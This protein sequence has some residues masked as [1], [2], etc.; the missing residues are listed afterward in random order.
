LISKIYVVES[1]TGDVVQKNNKSVLKGLLNCT[2]HDSSNEKNTESGVLKVQF[3]DVSYHHKKC[4]FCWEVSYFA[5]NELNTPI[6][7]IRSSSFKVFAR[8]PS[9]V[10][11]LTK[12]KRKKD[13]T[14]FD[15]FC[16]R[17]DELVKYTKKLKTD[18]QKSALELV[19]KKLLEFQNNQDR[20]EE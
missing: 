11:S 10:A 18:E 7:K 5:P 15:N 17:L 16:E 4:D 6:M 13:Q 9:T 8:K 19:S 20:D 1:T 12:K 2:I 14:D 3:T